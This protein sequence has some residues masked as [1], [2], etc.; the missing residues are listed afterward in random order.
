MKRSK[1]IFF[2]VVSLLVIVISVLPSFAYFD[3][4][5]DE[6]SIGGTWYL[7]EDII[8]YLQTDDY[9][10]TFYSGYSTDELSH[11]YIG[12]SVNTHIGTVSYISRNVATGADEY[13]PVYEDGAWLDYS[14]ATIIIPPSYADLTVSD[15]DQVYRAYFFSFLINHALDLTYY[16]YSLHA[17]NVGQENY[18]AGYNDGFAD[19]SSDAGNV[20]YVY[21]NG[22]N[23]GY[24]AGYSD[25]NDQGYNTGLTDGE[26]QGY[27][28]GYDDAVRDFDGDTIYQEGFRAGYQDGLID[29]DSYELDIPMVFDGLFGSLA[30][31]MLDT[32]SWEIFG[33]NV[34]GTM[35]AILLVSI[36]AWVITKVL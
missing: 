2:V 29:G 36:L 3:E 35:M 20:E 24:S 30:G 9:L 33:I 34:L 8:D 11:T 5:S 26:A 17:E 13:I 12:I 22:Y 31:L 4:T 32:L 27:Q 23:A 15:A 10:F 21:Q 19:G 14:Y 28:Q 16:N 6:I 1:K 7:P 25:G 18:S